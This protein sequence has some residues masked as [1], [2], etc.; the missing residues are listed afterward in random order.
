MR[1]VAISTIV[2]FESK[3]SVKPQNPKLTDSPERIIICGSENGATTTN[4][5]ISW[6]REPPQSEN[7]FLKKLTFRRGQING[8]RPPVFNDNSSRET[9]KVTYVFTPTC[10]R[11]PPVNIEGRIHPPIPWGKSCIIRLHPYPSY[12]ALFVYDTTHA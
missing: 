1:F 10:L 8:P 11:A 7:N 3:D 9:T 6:S 5:R 12:P 2:N 4:L